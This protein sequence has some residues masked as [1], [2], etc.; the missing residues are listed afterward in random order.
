MTIYSLDVL[1]PFP[2]WNQSIFPCPVLTVASWPAYR[3]LKRQVRWSGIPISFGIFHCL[4]C[5][6][7]TT[8]LLKGLGKSLKL[9]LSMSLKYTANLAWDKLI[10]LGQIRTWSKEKEKGVKE[11]IFFWYFKFQTEN[12]KISVC[13]SGFMYVS[14]Y[15][16]CFFLIIMLKL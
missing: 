1:T 5:S 15:V 12:Y 13:L 11:I 7:Q 14:V 9:T 2:I 3:F 10:C 8:I 4:L 16:F 6:T